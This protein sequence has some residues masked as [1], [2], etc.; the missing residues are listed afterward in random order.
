MLL[1]VGALRSTW[2]EWRWGEASRLPAGVWIGG[3]FQWLL[4]LVLV[5]VFAWNNLNNLL[6]RWLL[7]PHS[8]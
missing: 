7:H 5:A 1:A 8:P 4:L 2:I 3:A 6:E